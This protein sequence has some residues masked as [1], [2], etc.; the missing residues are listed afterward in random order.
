MRRY[1][2]GLAVL[3]IAMLVGPVSAA[4]ATCDVTITIPSDG[5]EGVVLTLDAVFTS[6]EPG[7][8]HVLHEAWPVVLGE[9]VTSRIDGLNERLDYRVDGTLHVMYLS[10]RAEDKVFSCAL[11][12]EWIGDVGCSC[13]WI[14]P[15]E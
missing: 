7:V 8:E 12:G 1:R 9:V 2:I 10:G 6:C 13:I 15:T 3:L 14:E 5:A 11:A 4:D